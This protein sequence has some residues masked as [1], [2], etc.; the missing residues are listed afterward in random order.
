VDAFFFRRQQFLPTGMKQQMKPAKV[1][2]LRTPLAGSRR[3][4]L[5]RN[6]IVATIAIG[7]LS[8]VAVGSNAAGFSFIES[9][10]EFFGIQRT[11]TSV[12]PTQKQKTSVL[13]PNPPGPDAD[14][15]IAGWD[16]T[17]AA[18]PVTFAATTFNANLVS[19][20]GANNIT[21]GAG[22]AASAGA[23]SFRT[24]GFQ[25]NGISTA[26]TDY[27]QI[28]LTAASGFST[29]LSAIDAN[30]N[31]TASFFASPGVTSQFAYS[32]NGVTFTLIGSPV[33][34]TSLAMTQIN[35]TGITALQ[36]VPSGTTVTLR[37]YASGQ[38]TTGGW[39]FFSAAAGTNGL[40]ITGS[41]NAVV[42]PPA[43]QA[44]NITFSSVQSTQ[45]GVNWTNGDGAKRIVK[46]NTSNS[47]TDPTDGTDPAANTV[48]GG[49]GEQVVF[50]NTGN[51]V[52]VTN[53]SPSTTYWFRVYEYN[54]AGATTK[55]LTTTA[56]NNPNSQATGAAASTPTKLAITSISPATPTAGSG[57]NVTVQSQ[58]NTNAQAN[59]SADT[60]F[61][62]SNTGGGTIGGTTTGT[63]T[64][65]TSQVVVTGVTLSAAGTGVT[66]TATRNSGD[67]LTAG[68]SAPFTVLS[69]EPTV[70]TSAVNFTNVTQNS[71]TVNWT[72][73]NG[74]ARIVLAKSGSAVNSDPVDGASYTASS[75]FGSGGTQ[76]GTG[77]FVVFSGSGNSVTVTG[78]AGGTTYHFA[79]YEFNGAGGT[80]NYLTSG[81]AIGNQ[82]TNIATYTWNQTGS[83]AWTTATNWTPT[84]TTPAS[85]DVL[86]FNGGGSVTVTS[87]PTQTIGQLLI[88]NNSTVLL[89]AAAASTTLTISGG[90]GTDLSVGNG[91]ALNVDTT[92]AMAI[93]VATGATGSISGAMTVSGAAGHT[94]TA[95]DASGITFNSGA[96]FTQGTA[97]TGNV[98][99][100]GT[101]N[102]IVFTSSSTFIQISGSNPFQKTAP[103][104]VVVFQTGS[105]FSLQGN[106]TPAFSG[107]TYAN[108]EMNALGV[109]ATVT[110]TAATSVDNLT[111]TQGTFN[112]N[113]TAT[114]GHA[115]KGNISVASGATLNFN[116]LAAGTV[117]LNGTA[118]QSISGSGTLTFAANQTVVVNNSAGV[119]LNRSITL[120]GTLTL[121]S[122]ALSIGANTLTLN[123]AIT[124]GSGTLTGGA[125][126]NIVFG[127][128]GASTALP[129][130]TLND[131][132]I[133]R[134]NGISL[135]G[136]VTTGG[137]LT[138]TNGTLS[139]GNRILTLNGDTSV[140][141]GA[142]D[143]STGTV[144]YFQTAAGQHVI[145]AN[146]FLLAFSG[147]SKILP[148]TGT[149]G[150]VD[151]FN[152]GGT[153][154]H[155]I[156]GSTFDFK[157]AGTQTIPVFNYYNLTSSS[158]GNREFGVGTVGIENVFVPGGNLYGAGPNFI[159]QAGSIV[160]YNGT[161]AQTMPNSRGFKYRSLSINNGAGVTAPD[162]T[163]QTL[164]IADTL[165]LKNGIFTLNTGNGVTMS[166]GATINRSGG[167]I[168][169]TP[170]VVGSDKYNVTFSGA[171][172]L[173]A[174]PEIPS[175]AAVLGNLTL[176]Q[177]AGDVDASALAYNTTVNGTL[178][179][180]QNTNLYMGSNILIMGAGS[181]PTTSGA[182]QGEVIGT[183]RRTSFINTT[184]YSFGSPFVQF[185]TF[186]WVGAPTSVDVAMTPE[187]P[188]D[189]SQ[190]VKRTYQIDV[191]GG[192]GMSTT[193]RLHYL[194]GD[195]LNGNDENTLD[196]WKGPTWVDL[197][198]TL[199]SASDNWIEHAGVT[200]FSP[201]TL[202]P[203]IVPTAVKLSKFNAV[204]YTDGVQLTWESGFEVNNLGYRIY[205]EQNGKR[206]RVTPS[207]VAG[208]ALTVGQGNRL[209]AGFSYS[210][211]DPQGTPGTGYYLEAID[212]D[213]SRQ[214]H[215]PIYPYGGSR[216]GVSPKQQRALLLNELGKSLANNS[217]G[218]DAT[219]WPASMP[220]SARSETLK[221]QPQSL[222]AQQAIAGGKAV[223][224]QVRQSGWYRVTQPELI[225][226]GFDPAY[227]ARLL[228]LYV[229]GEEVPVRLSAEGARLNS[230]DTLEFYGVAL[231]TQTTD[232]RTYWLVNGTTAGKRITAKR[233]KI[234]AGDQNWTETAGLH[235]FPFTAERR[236][237]L[238][239]SPRLLNGDGDNIFGALIFT[240]PTE[241]TLAVKNFDHEAATPVQLEVALQGLTA[242]GHDVHVMLNGADLGSMTFGASAHSIATFAVNRAL[243]RE[244]DNTVS[245]SSGNGDSDIS[246]VDYVRLTYAHQ[247]TA[248]NNALRFSVPG[249]GVVRVD[250]FTTANIRVVDITDPS[251]PLEL[252]T[253][254][255]PSGVGYSVKVQALGSNI[256][257]LMAFADDMAAHPASI[258]ANKPS[259]WNASA[260]GADLVIITHKDFRQ[261][262]EPLAALRR[263]Q[264][265][266]VAV[267]DVEDVYDEFSYGAHTPAAIKAFLMNAAGTWAR[268][269]GY[270]LLV[271]DSSW[272][273]RNFMDQGANDFVPTK[274]LDTNYMETASDDWL[275]DFTGL[276]RADMA[277]GRLPG[278]TAAEVSLMVSKILAYEQER[279]L[280]APLRGAV[281]VADNGFENQSAATSELLPAGVARQSLNRAAIGN[282]DLMRGQLL[283]AL[284][285]GPMIVNFYGH[286]SIGVWTGAGVL[287]SDLADT[288]S[289]TNRSS[290]YLMMT[291]LNGYAH[292]AYVD[293]LGES[294]LKAPNGGAVAVWASSGFTPTDPQF[295]MDSQF[296]RLLFGGQS[297]RLGEA[298]RQAKLATSD[299][300]V[301]RTWILL[302]D[303]TMRVR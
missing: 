14:S 84:R 85:S 249:G 64:T 236:E 10:K 259:N 134:A 121:T 173:V 41:T 170:A 2:R 65:G 44:S 279:E 234:K 184:T 200:T 227:D 213:S 295:A 67:L 128:A 116:P 20:S 51:S 239:Y 8:F 219:G 100:S 131:L 262:I 288:L 231:D 108:F 92:N 37:Y 252:A 16:F 132:T 211:F 19:A 242:Q 22:A 205:R 141:G 291:C 268:K 180:N 187:R 29:S 107:R 52:T 207:I 93:A 31:G 233:N 257:T 256:R 30:F 60:G 228:Q 49:S 70:Q 157:G 43:T 206:T 269:P 82:A 286:G 115:I 188:L 175:G 98:F 221:L 287:D 146:Y 18:A 50:N 193:L 232:T 90:A 87:V 167:S 54:G 265:L 150:I 270:L 15:I 57:F 72:N 176:S 53:L 71:M 301:R 36:N 42:S 33:T 218:A 246:F 96:T 171:A 300:D 151:T 203:V 81:P 26:N 102:S 174:G 101:S 95:A 199:R 260:N 73:G 105:L 185:G 77:N 145:A 59:V 124:V 201:W 127:G 224:L 275:V 147:G 195:V 247:Y 122:G 283:E 34:S 114:P 109:T 63:I 94:L 123:G 120:D 204:S 74:A 61:T 140:T 255:S 99:G 25:N 78:L 148:S 271:G 45:M 55:F 156:T 248:D 32:L 138:L 282:D 272:D 130:V 110:G 56:T 209:T 178:T 111:I 284:N 253:S 126:S 277:L 23:N 149:V 3:L 75:T 168:T 17:G 46:I 226:A 158:T 183:V 215:G 159:P 261:A 58:D 9:V 144:N 62:L 118:G 89:E 4:N 48:Y 238:V 113:M 91:S 66:L 139:V 240:D 40:A 280:N 258:T 103:A 163:G 181:S 97:A 165:L 47:F 182:G 38:T 6:A 299:L 302:G 7:A 154:G 244:G 39:G 112:F 303:P 235:S 293:S 245:L 222:A 196:L 220:A 241:Q 292:D 125:T 266:S 106:V 294:V 172:A 250:G 1:N 276:G 137:I 190:A 237:K 76:I 69:A 263:D 133:N 143:A 189:F 210:W 135:G 251:S 243:L 155:T 68:T 160:E 223:K 264:G 119:S 197:P 177:T 191:S 192:T 86:Q 35:L 267:V 153:S 202:A 88:S 104:S 214:T 289:N 298:A 278:R 152:P 274:L 169:A 21:R 142:L 24:V 162:L 161:S 129:A 136:D 12:A 208:S 216:N 79:V 186:T 217:G 194:D 229:D 28:T 11:Q 281:M 179:M 230:N 290:I 166:D 297:L 80:E 285:Q 13:A 5:R 296:Y 83:A 273:P 254:G 164:L 198:A 225:A 27:F 117:N 212:L